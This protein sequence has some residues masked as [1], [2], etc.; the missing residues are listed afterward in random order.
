MS[1]AGASPELPRSAWLLEL[2]VEPYEGILDL[3]RQ[4]AQSRQ[5]DEIGDGLILLEH[6]PVITLGRRA[7]ERHILASSEV[8]KKEGISVYRVE[9]GGDV[10]YHG[11]GQIVGYP[12]LRLADYGLGVSDYMHLLEEIIVRVLADLGL[13]GTRRERTIGVWLGDNKVAAF[14]ARVQKGV[15]YHGFAFNVNPNMRHYDL[16]IPCGITD[17]GVTSLQSELGE[18]AD[19]VYTRQLVRHWFS[20]LFRVRLEPV[21]TGELQVTVETTATR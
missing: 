5:R 20:E 21:S 15:T 2:G 14:G 3:Q 19:L 10:T 17:G 13:A 9:R 12:I 18:A 4:L 16:I 8:L 11:P 1:P 6:A 7:E